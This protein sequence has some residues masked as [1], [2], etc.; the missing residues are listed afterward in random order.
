MKMKKRVSLTMA[1][2]NSLMNLAAGYFT[3]SLNP[4][5]FLSTINSSI[6]RNMEPAEL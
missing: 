3:M 2:V 5:I 1:S 6:P 4:L